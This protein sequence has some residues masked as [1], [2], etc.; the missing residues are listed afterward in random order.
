LIEGE[1][2]RGFFDER[3]PTTTGPGGKSSIA[4]YQV[5]FLAR[6]MKKT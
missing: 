5:R 1:K 6:N 2:E 4:Q 3:R